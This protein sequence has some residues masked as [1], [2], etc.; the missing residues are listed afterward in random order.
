MRD[1]SSWPANVAAKAAFLQGEEVGARYLRRLRIAAE[2]ERKIISFPDVYERLAAEV[3]GLDLERLRT[4][5]AD[6]T[7]RL[8]FEKDL[9]FC[10]EWETYGFP[11]MLFYR[12]GA[13]IAHLTKKNAVYL[14]GHRTME[15]YD[16]VVRTIAPDVRTFEPRDERT[17]LATYGP[18]TERELGQVHGRDKDAELEVMLGLEADGKVFRSPRVRGNVWSLEPIEGDFTEGT[19]E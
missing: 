16:T 7:A 17:L 2:T 9:A 6:G 11:T 14:G 5:V 3:E 8:A 12:H 1:F 18:M 13:D 10:A 15:T 19:V 4:D